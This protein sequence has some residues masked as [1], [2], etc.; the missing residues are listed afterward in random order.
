MFRQTAFL[1][2]CPPAL[3]ERDRKTDKAPHLPQSHWAQPGPRILRT[4]PAEL[5]GKNGG[6]LSKHVCSDEGELKGERISGNC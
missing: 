3:A 1:A 6:S 2:P 5:D 4:R